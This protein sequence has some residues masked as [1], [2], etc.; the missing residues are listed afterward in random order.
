MYINSLNINNNFS[1]IKT[2]NYSFLTDFGGRKKVDN[3]DS[4]CHSKKPLSA[5]DQKILEHYRNPNNGYGSVSS[6]CK[7]NNFS[8]TKYN[9]VVKKFTSVEER[10]ELEKQKIEFA[11]KRREEQK[12]NKPLSKIDSAILEDYR[13]INNGFGSIGEFCRKNGISAVKYNN[14]LRE[15]LSWE[16]IEQIR[17]Q[18]YKTHTKFNKPAS[19]KS[20]SSNS[21]AFPSEDNI[22]V[23]SLERINTYCLQV[24]EEI[25]DITDRP[26]ASQ[27]DV[28]EKIQALKDIKN[29][30]SVK[31]RNY[32]EISKEYKILH[33]LISQLDTKIKM[34]SKQIEKFNRIKGSS[35]L[36]NVTWLQEEDFENKLFSHQKL[37]NES[38]V[39]HCEQSEIDD[40]NNRLKE[41]FPEEC[42]IFIEDYDTMRTNKPSEQKYTVYGRFYES[43]NGKKYG[44]LGTRK[45][46]VIEFFSDRKHAY[47]NFI[48][49]LISN[50]KKITEA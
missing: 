3:V 23:S 2:S 27:V 43:N 4:F 15:R 24:K 1:Y 26:I 28:D 30:V 11:K 46:F 8:A 45:K 38:L 20:V 9:F 41:A 22:F 17:Q 37:L 25:G 32:P 19:S 18:K 48:D 12:K 10:K 49:N 31:I 42:V 13:N 39:E 47:K 35:S 44:Q 34:I 14:V 29:E 21:N 33:D 5:I 6:F 16:E 40:A 36:P 7:E 50:K